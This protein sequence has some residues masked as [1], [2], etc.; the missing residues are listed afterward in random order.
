M[1]WQRAAGSRHGIS[2]H[3]NCHLCLLSVAYACPYHNPTVTMV[4]CSQCWHQQTAR[5]HDSIHSW[6]RD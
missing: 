2:V 5:P 6:N 3:S 4:H 1:A